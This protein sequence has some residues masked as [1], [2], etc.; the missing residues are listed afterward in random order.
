MPRSLVEL[1][2]EALVN[3]PCD[4]TEPARDVLGVPGTQSL[5]PF[6]FVAGGRTGLASVAGP[7]KASLQ[8]RHEPSN[9]P[10]DAPSEGDSEAPEPPLVPVAP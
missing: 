1:A 6:A 3:L 10:A 8:A 2:E 5:S 4:S 7:A 9:R